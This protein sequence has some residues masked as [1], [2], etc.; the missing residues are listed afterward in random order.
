MQRLGYYAMGISLGHGGTF[1]PILASWGPNLLFIFIG[2]Y[3]IL[4]LDSEKLL[5]I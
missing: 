5:P 2:F 3:L 4:T 1:N